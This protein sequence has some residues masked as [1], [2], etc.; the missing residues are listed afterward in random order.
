MRQKRNAGFTL[1]ELAVGI[2]VLALLLGGL[3]IPLRTQVE[4]R[5]IDETQRI[6][7]QAREAL[8]GYVVAHGYFPCPADAASNGAEANGPNP[9]DSVTGTCGANTG[10]GDAGFHGFLP[11]RALGISP[12]DSRGYAIDAWGRFDAIDTTPPNSRNDNRIRYSVYSDAATIGR[13]LVRSG[14]MAALGIPALGGG[15]FFHVCL[16][17]TGVGAAD[18]GATAPPAQVTLATNAVAVIWSAGANAGT[19]G[20]SVHEAQNPNPN[21]GSADR[22]FVS[23]SASD[24]AATQ[25]DDVMTWIPITV[26]VSRLVAG[27]QL[28]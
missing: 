26:V 3:L 25:F 9:H 11:A 27:G 1:V 12:V 16:S 18:C 24:V 2:V 6:L 4:V 19:G 22:V 21:G 14:G 13:S 20:A 17:G 7:A 10:N 8:L 5:K 23:R 28:P 15:S